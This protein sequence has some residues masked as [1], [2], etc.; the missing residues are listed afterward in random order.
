[1][2]D[3]ITRW[4]GRA[5]ADEPEL[6]ERARQRKIFDLAVKDNDDRLW[7]ATRF[8]SET[9]DP[10]VN[11]VKT[12]LEFK[13]KAL[14]PDYLPDAAEEAKFQDATRDAVR[15]IG[16][17]RPESIRA[18]RR[19][20]RGDRRTPLVGWYVLV[21][22]FLIV[23]LLGHGYHASIKSQILSMQRSET[24][25][26]EGLQRMNSMTE[27]VSKVM[28]DMCGA[29]L[30][31]RANAT[32]LHRLLQLIPFI[33]VHDP[34]FVEVGPPAGS[35]IPPGVA[36]MLRKEDPLRP[37]VCAVLEQKVK[38]GGFPLFPTAAGA[39]SSD[40]ESQRE[41]ASD[42]ALAKYRLETNV[43][44]QAVVQARF[45]NP[46]IRSAL[47]VAE[48]AA[49]FLNM[50]LLPT[51]FALL[52]S[53]T[54]ALMMANRSIKMMTLT[55]LDNAELVTVV[56][57]GV[58]AGASIGIVFN[59]SVDLAASSGLTT[60]GLAFAAGYGVQVFYNLLDGVLG[61]LG[62]GKKGSAQDG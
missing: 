55:R 38:T 19:I 30:D 60:L 24:Q 12:L 25:Y 10:P 6:D 4:F 49:L 52:G 34:R 46:A 31:Y 61:A 21:G 53:L 59:S 22:V 23:A 32:Q 35:V 56:L 1:M 42:D 57:L 47:S 26:L 36:P 5:G 45:T 16:N 44:R 54:R 3:A 58:V 51:L 11:T 48:T 15:W 7:Y 33:E 39:A 14:D 20:Q 37:G 43:L 9:S 17:R 28:F 2:V 27:E 18:F 13:E 40:P 8:W 41:R 50:L 62:G 29:T